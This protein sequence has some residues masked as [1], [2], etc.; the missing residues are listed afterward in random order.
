MGSATSDLQRGNENTEPEK[1]A[2]QGQP[3]SGT[4]VPADS[5]SAAITVA[6][7]QSS[8]CIKHQTSSSQ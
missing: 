1:E 7:Q 5:E 8:G 6:A 2:G 4:L 3:E